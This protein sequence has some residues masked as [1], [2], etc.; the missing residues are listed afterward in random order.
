MT[1]AS[2]GRQA[3]DHQTIESDGGLKPGLRGLAFGKLTPERTD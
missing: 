1:K 2:A 3:L